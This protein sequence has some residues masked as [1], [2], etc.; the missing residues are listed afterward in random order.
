MRLINFII[1]CT[2]LILTTLPVR[3]ESIGGV[4]L[5]K[6]NSIIDRK[7]GEKDVKV[8]KNLDIFSYD[9]VKTGKGQVAIEFLDETRVDITQHSKLIID[10]FVYD[11]NTKTGKLSLKATLGT[12]RY[13]SGQIAKNSAQNI[14]IK[15]PTATVS[16]RGTDFAMT[17]DEIGSST[18]ILLPS[19]NGAGNCF[20]GEISVE[21]DAGQVILNQAFQATQVDT[22][23]SSPLKPVLLD[24]DENLINNLLIVQKPPA[25]AD[26]IEQEE[27]LKLVANALDIDFLKFDDLD[28]DLLETEED[29]A[30]T[31]L[32]IDFLDQNFLVDI[33]AQL[34]KQLAIQMRSQ[35]DK[36]SKSKTGTDEFGVTL[37]DEDPE[38]VWM[39]SDEA[40]NNIVLR[41]N[42][43][44][45]YIINVTQGDMEIRDYQ[46]GEGDNEIYINQR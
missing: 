46:L 22:P 28:V 7:D 41:L 9:T 33:L 1:L 27:K 14:S 40:G 37:L 20:V 5:S 16:V 10:D 42:Q 45:G 11:P 32:E 2:V 8:E 12:V 18:I 15:T 29:E 39:R 43:E 17:I 4:T 13:A 30:V 34:N 35:F 26:A 21:S 38:W 24:L 3:S 31:A 36:K 19:C 23:E 6:G 25:L 44:N